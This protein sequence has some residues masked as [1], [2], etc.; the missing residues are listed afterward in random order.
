M[1]KSTKR[2]YE[3]ALQTRKTIIQYIAILVESKLVDNKEQARLEV[4]YDFNHEY[5]IKEIESFCYST[6]AVVVVIIIS[7]NIVN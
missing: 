7:M 3:T 4:H 6:I 5:I 2:I 1:R